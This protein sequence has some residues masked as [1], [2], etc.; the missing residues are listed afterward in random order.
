MAIKIFFTILNLHAVLQTLRKKNMISEP[1]VFISQN[2]WM[3]L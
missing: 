1:A 3:G 2:D